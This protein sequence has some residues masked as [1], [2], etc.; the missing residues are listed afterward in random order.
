MNGSEIWIKHGGVSFI[1]EN[2]R[3]INIKYDSMTKLPI[4]TFFKKLIDSANTLAL[5]GDLYEEANQ[6]LSLLQKWL[7]KMH[8]NLGYM[9]LHHLQWFGQKGF[10]RPIGK[11]FGRTKKS[12]PKC[13][14][15]QFSKQESNT[16]PGKT[17]KV[18]DTSK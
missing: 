9:G 5:L 1:L 18:D 2:N 15:C 6:N 16:K 14:T 12:L 17:K 3:C 10:F 7:L 4:M 11:K 13:T 8:I